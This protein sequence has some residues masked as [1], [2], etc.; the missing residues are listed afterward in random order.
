MGQGMTCILFSSSSAQG[1][2]LC[3]EMTESDSLFS[4]FSIA[5]HLGTCICTAARVLSEV[6]RTAHS[7]FSYVTQSSDKL[8]NQSLSERLHGTEDFCLEEGSCFIIYCWS[9][10]IFICDMCPK[11]VIYT[12]LS[13]TRIHLLISSHHKCHLAAS[14]YHL[15]HI[16]PHKSY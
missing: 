10:R 8:K 14:G 9:C 13:T 3:E 6:V 12:Q 5:F 11:Y 4:I 2:E 7:N 1:Q 15:G 16:C